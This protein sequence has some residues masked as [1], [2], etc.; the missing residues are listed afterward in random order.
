MNSP[1]K[2]V[3]IG[4]GFIGTSIYNYFLNSNY[5]VSIFNRLK[6]DDLIKQLAKIEYQILIN[7]SGIGHPTLLD[8]NPVEYDKEIEHIKSII[9]IANNYNL[10]LIHYSSAAACGYDY[11]F[12]EKLYPVTLKNTLYG[13]LKCEVENTISNKIDNENYIILRLF[14]VYGVGLKKQ[15]FF[16][17]YN[18]YQKNEHV[19]QLNS[20][21]DE[22]NFTSILDVIKS[23]EFI[24]N[25]NLVSKRV[26][27]I[28]NDKPIKI[29]TAIKIGYS[30]LNKINNK[31]YQPLISVGRND[32]NNN[33]ISMH[34]KMSNLRNAGF[35]IHSSLEENLYN[36]Y[37]WLDKKSN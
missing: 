6:L 20:I 30:I 9:S 19:F 11:D 29:S 22:R 35:Y 24:I 27:N 8:K 17:L 26:I 32:L 13:R 34:P 28:S 10:F 15:L 18:K 33:F 14:S 4:D 5:N 36:Y 16:D 2:I 7:C 1:N 37:L 3:I 23:T 25:K 31:N 12:E 21:L